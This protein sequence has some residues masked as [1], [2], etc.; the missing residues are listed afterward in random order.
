MAKKH[1]QLLEDIPLRER[2]GLSSAV[3]TY[4]MRHAQVLIYSLGQLWR[5]PFSLIM[6]AAV[7]GIALA[8]PTGLHVL[9]KNAQHIS[10]GWDGA[11]KV[12]LFLKTTTTDEQARK[13]RNQ[14]QKLPEIAEVDYISR[15]QALAE[16][17]RKSGFGEALTALKE[18]P[19]PAVLIVTPHL[20]HSDA[21]KVESLSHRLRTYKHVELA[22]LDRQWVKRLYAIMDIVGRGVVV[23]GAMLAIA[24]LLV[25]GNTIRLAI[26]N[27]RDEIV[28][29]KL[30]GG[31]D[32]FIRRP[33][34]YTGFWYGFIGGIMALILVYLA[35]WS[36]S[37]PVEKL[38]GMYQSE[39]TLQKLDFGTITILLFLSITLGLGGS[40]IAVGRH[41]R[42]IE[43]R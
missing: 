29:I 6:T 8:L 24:V 36:V 18:N 14:I 17:K 21:D 15:N 11:A 27:R 12:S 31:T 23:L 26:Q 5:A 34:L 40:W 4:F 32:A 30:I 41:L 3:K 20:Q 22:Q 35:V 25:V 7:I 13:L 19:L 37:S 9:L 2:P 16:F 10:G 33:F 42:E 43:P 28:I 38:A 39:L 1:D